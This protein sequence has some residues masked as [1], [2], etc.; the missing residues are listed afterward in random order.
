MWAGR[1][2]QHTHALLPTTP[3]SAAYGGPVLD[4]VVFYAVRPL[5]C[6]HRCTAS[7]AA[8][9][10]LRA[11]PA[12]P[13]C[14]SPLADPV[15]FRALRPQQDPPTESFRAATQHY[16]QHRFEPQLKARAGAA[17]WALV[18]ASARGGAR[19]ASAREA[20]VAC[21]ALHAPTSSHS[22][23]RAQAA[24]VAYEVDIIVE[25]VDE[26][27]GSV[28]DA[29]CRKADDLQAAAVRGRAGGGGMLVCGAL[30]A[31]RCCWHTGGRN[32]AGW[33]E[34]LPV[35]RARAMRLQPPST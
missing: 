6:R 2:P 23:T 15:C 20:L 19:T 1:G 34:R 25:E 3:C 30:P 28:G 13:S 7:A 10:A 21:A 14:P 22:R 12:G 18:W 27:V 11:L 17:A 5:A 26:S 16:V 29:I 31:G 35:R 8:L 24:G 4:G 33:P 9:P 32:A